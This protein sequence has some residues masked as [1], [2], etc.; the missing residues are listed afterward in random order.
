MRKHKIF[1][2]VFVSASLFLNTV[3]AFAQADRDFN[4]FWTKFKNAV[5]KK[6]KNV[7]AG[8]TSFPV[9]MPYGVSSVKTKAAFLRRYDEI[10]N[11]EADAKQCFA[12]AKPEK[13][14]NEYEVACGFKNDPD[15][16]GGT[17]LVYSFTLTKAGW[18]F[19][20]LDNINE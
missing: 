18:R 17:P 6:N 4:K 14:G 13:Q 5:I 9:S 11:G 8:L 15:G 2:V 20:G 16:S 12:K 7:V 3:S 10:F 19:S 1:L